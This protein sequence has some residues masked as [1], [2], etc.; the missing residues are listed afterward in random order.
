MSVHK[1]QVPAQSDTPDHSIAAR[2]ERL[3]AEA[4]QLAQAHAADFERS[5]AQTTALAAEIAAG[6]EAYPVGVRETARQLGDA[7]AA[8]SL[9]LQTLRVREGF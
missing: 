2:M 9:R 3:M 6:G 5:I 1:F 4:T 8:A 7:L